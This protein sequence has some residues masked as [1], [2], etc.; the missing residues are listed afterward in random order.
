MGKD[1]HLNFN[2]KRE[3]PCSEIQDHSHTSPK[4]G[5]CSQLRAWP[6]VGKPDT[7]LKCWG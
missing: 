2:L 7:L 4:H 6:L 3:K 1:L 5:G